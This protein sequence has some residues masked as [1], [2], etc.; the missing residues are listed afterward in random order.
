MPGLHALLTAALLLPADLPAAAGDREV[1][2][3]E[4]ISNF[5]TLLEQAPAPPEIGEARMIELE[6]SDPETYTFISGAKAHPPAPVK[7]GGDGRL[8]LTRPDRGE[9]VTAVYRR[10]DGSYDRKEVEKIQWIMR[11]TG[12]GE[13]TQLSILLLEILDAVEDKFGGSGLVLL[14]GYRAPRLNSRVPGAARYSLHMLGWAA[15]IRVPRRSARK[16]AAFARKLGAGGVGYYPDAAFVHLDAGRPR[17]W[18]LRR[19]APPASR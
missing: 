12:G 19:S 2:A 6:D 18:T 14:S 17:H 1:S 7:L 8:T 13:Q 16:V 3:S 10:K 5:Q 11:S 15:D 9:R 4:F